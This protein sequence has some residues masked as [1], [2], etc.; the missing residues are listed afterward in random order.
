[1]PPAPAPARSIAACIAASTF[2]MLAHAEIIV[3]APDGDVVAEIVVERARELAGAP[4]EIGEHAITPLGAQRVQ[5]ALEEL[6]VIHCHK[7]K[8]LRVIPAEAGIQGNVSSPAQGPCFRGDDD[9]ISMPFPAHCTRLPNSRREPLGGLVERAAEALQ[10]LVDLAL[11]DDQRRAQGD[12]VAAQNPHDQ[13]M[14]L[15]SRGEQRAGALL[16]VER[17]LVCLSATSSI[18]AISPTP[19]TSPTSG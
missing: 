19:R 9:E 10:Q 5:P 1:M 16:G 4:L 14:L 3:G 12:A 8:P 13:A 15:A 17:S 6:L 7:S 11:V 18:A 2:G